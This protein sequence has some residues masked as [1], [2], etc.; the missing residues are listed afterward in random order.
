MSRRRCVGHAAPWLAVVG[1]VVA[2]ATLARAQAAVP[3]ADPFVRLLPL[4]GRWE[5]TSE[6]EPGKGVVRREYARALNDRFIHV[7]N[8]S[9]YPPQEKNPK[10]EL[11]RDEGFI[12]HDRGR[13]ALIFRQFHVEGFV[14]QYVEAPT[15]T[16]TRVVFESEAIENIPAGFRARE[17][18]VI[19]GPDAFEEIFELAEP[20]KDFQVY[21]RT[22]LR[23]AK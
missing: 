2:A 15:S 1:L 12:S 4:L 14:N 13:K 7:T 20:G 22:T 21:S 17:T 23:R 18:Y 5:G 3:P 6:G 11:H 9:E 19:S 8:R 16:A 10:G